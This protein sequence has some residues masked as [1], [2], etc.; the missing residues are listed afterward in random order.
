M[1]E[2]NDERRPITLSDE[3]LNQLADKLAERT[4]DAAWDRFATFVGRSVLRNL[5]VLAGVCAIGVIAWVK[6]K[7]GQA[8]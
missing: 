7:T 5:F 8:T 1:S 2:P 6:L 4:A 3:Q